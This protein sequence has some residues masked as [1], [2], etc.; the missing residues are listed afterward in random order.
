MTEFV[1]T[2]I[3][4]RWTIRLPTFRAARP[5]WPTWEATRLAAMHGDISEAV[6]NGRRP[7]VY[8]IG[9]EEGDM[10]CLYHQW[11]AD[12]V[13]VEPNPAVWPTLA[14]TLAANDVIPTGMFH[15]FCA[16]ATTGPVVVGDLT[17]LPP[18]ADGPI[19][20]DH[21]ESRLTDPTAA[22]VPQI[23]LD[24][25]TALCGPPDVVTIDVEG[26]EYAVLT[27]AA[28]TLAAGPVVYVSVHS[29]DVCAENGFDPADI[30]ATMF[31]AG[32]RGVMLDDDH[33]QHWRFTRRL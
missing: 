33:E 9:A 23:R 19:R 5:E 14:A 16:A 29:P 15:G 13:V 21:G 32:Y 27:G 7:V 25:L 26:G 8:D 17:R 4:N 31:D 28:R 1:D 11:G 3:N 6:D 10:T 20:G 22:T 18:A 12:V 30:L 24:D 2:L